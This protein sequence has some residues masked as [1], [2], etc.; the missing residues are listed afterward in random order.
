LTA[1]HVGEVLADTGHHRV[2]VA[3]L[4]AVE[5][6]RITADGEDERER[7][8]RREGQAVLEQA[9]RIFVE[10]LFSAAEQ[11]RAA[12]LGEDDPRIA[13]AVRHADT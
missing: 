2:I 11:E 5:E 13:D 7:Q 4:R 8:L 1:R 6:D 3:T 10:R 12:E 9:Y